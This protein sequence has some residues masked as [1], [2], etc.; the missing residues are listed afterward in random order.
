MG[1]DLVGLGSSLPEKWMVERWT[2]PIYSG[3]MLVSGSEVLFFFV[4]FS[5][6]H[7]PPPNLAPEM[8]P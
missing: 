2:R 1:S 7:E 6:S 8:N 3:N 4:V 5:S